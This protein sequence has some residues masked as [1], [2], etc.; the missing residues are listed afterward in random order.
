MLTV[1]MK[2]GVQNDNKQSI[3][4]LSQR[5]RKLPLGNAAAAYEIVSMHHHQ[6]KLWISERERER[7]AAQSSEMRN[8]KLS[9]FLLTSDCHRC[10][11]L[12][13]K[14][15]IMKS[16]LHT[17]LRLILIFGTLCHSFKRRTSRHN[18]PLIMAPCLPRY[19]PYLN[20][21]LES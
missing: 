17:K 14:L 13:S 2:M 16:N 21:Y 7:K 9:L 5:D 12:H 8:V 1:L 6:E 3:A 18:H 15:P 4:P 20:S 10:A 19:A 11:Q